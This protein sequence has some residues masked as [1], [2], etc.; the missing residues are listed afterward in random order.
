M[1]LILYEDSMGTP[2]N[3]SRRGDPSAAWSRAPSKPDDQMISTGQSGLATFA[4]LG[5]FLPSVVRMT[6]YIVGRDRMTEYGVYS[7]SAE[8]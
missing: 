4:S 1:A 5:F 8:W 3:S 2:A 6:E 7:R